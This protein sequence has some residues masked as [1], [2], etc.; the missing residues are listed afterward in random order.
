[1][2]KT[3]L[4]TGASTGIGAATARRLAAGNEMIIHYH[5]SRGAAEAVAG[6][7]REAGGVAHCVQADLATEAGCRQLAAFATERCGKLDV[8]VNNAGGLIRR[9]SAR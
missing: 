9:Q 6:A 4:I 7:V 1:M 5:A 3:I 8:L 2:K